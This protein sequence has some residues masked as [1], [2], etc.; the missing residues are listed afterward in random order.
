[1]KRFLSTFKEPAVKENMK[2]LLD[3]NGHGFV[4]K[5]SIIIKK[6]WIDFYGKIL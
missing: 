6:G 5:G 1:V 4:S 2:V 3:V